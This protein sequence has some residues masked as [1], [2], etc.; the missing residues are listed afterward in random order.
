MLYVPLGAWTDKPRGGEVV[1]PADLIIIHHWYIPDVPES[2]TLEES[3]KAMR[4]VENAHIN[5][6]WGNSTGYN[7]CI[8]DNGLIFEGRGLFRK[9]AHTQYQNGRSRGIAFMNN[10]DQA[11]PT[12][13]AWNACRDLIGYLTG[14]GDVKPTFQLK[15]HHDYAPKS[16]PGTLVYPHLAELLTPQ[17]DDM[18][19]DVDAA[20]LADLHSLFMGDAGLA[21]GP[22]GRITIDAIAAA[23]VAKLPPGGGATPDQIKAAVKA[24]LQE[25]TA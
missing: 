11:R 19:S 20:R 23:V 17:E 10:G 18:F 15:G 24:A 2:A 14:N 9:G 25:G 7:W 5:N 13:K 8:G 21:T 6:G 22:K 4:A 12:P 16:C 3:K 1:G